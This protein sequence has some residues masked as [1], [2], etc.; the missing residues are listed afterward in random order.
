MLPPPLLLA[1][2]CEGRCVR[3]VCSLD[4][5]GPCCIAHLQERFH[6][7]QRPATEGRRQKALLRKL[8]A[9]QRQ[10]DGRLQAQLDGLRAALAS[11]EQR[12]LRARRGSAGKGGPA[13]GAGSGMGGDA[14]LAQMQAALASLA[15]QQ[16]TQAREQAAWQR[17]VMGQLQTLNAK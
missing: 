11:S 12:Q 1:I 16:A 17:E 10:R 14:G 4:P 15:Q 9:E 7:E 13:G 6:E 8:V 3:A 2:H 5:T